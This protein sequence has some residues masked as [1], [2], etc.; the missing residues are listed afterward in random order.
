[1]R[2]CCIFLCVYKRFMQKR[3]TTYRCYGYYL[4]VKGLLLADNDPICVLII[5]YEKV[6]EGIFCSGINVMISISR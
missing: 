3:V 4:W 1:M 2:Y 5:S 6:S